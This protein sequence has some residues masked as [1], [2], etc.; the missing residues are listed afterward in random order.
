M[1]ICIIVKSQVPL[2]HPPVVEEASN[3][4]F[5]QVSMHLLGGSLAEILEQRVIKNGVQYI[6]CR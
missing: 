3:A 1:C 5:N 4:I 2:L 6:H